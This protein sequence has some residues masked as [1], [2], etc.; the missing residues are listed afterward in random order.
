MPNASISRK[1]ARILRP[2]DLRIG[3]F[4]PFSTIDFPDRIAAV[5]FCQGC[6][7]RCGY[8]HN[9]RLIPSRAEG[10][11]DWR[12]IEE[13]LRNRTGLL[14]AVVFSGGEPL[15]QRALVSAI[16]RV[17]E[18]G[19]AIG[20]H[21]S[22]ALPERFVRVLPFVDWTGFDIKA[23]FADYP[24]VTRIEG[25][26]EKAKKALDALIRSGK[27]FEARTTIEPHHFTPSSF[28]RFACELHRLG[29]RNFALQEARSP[30]AAARASMT[31]HPIFDDAGLMRDTGRLFSS[32]IMRRAAP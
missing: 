11:L 19:F 20:L 16:R 31:V 1:P 26:G 10:L 23:A 6:P 8:C 7:L 14:D 29:V 22:G 21:T 27:P 9:R 13:R 15:A 25:S 18:L 28:A 32:F 24:A 17:K 12:R 4:E 2:D 5:I 3:G 30:D